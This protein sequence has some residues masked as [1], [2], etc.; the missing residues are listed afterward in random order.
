MN[1]PWRIGGGLL[2]IG[3]V[4]I[5][6]LLVYP[7]HLLPAWIY[8]LM[9]GWRYPQMT[10]VGDGQMTDFGPAAAADRFVVD[11]GSLD[12]S[13]AGRTTHILSDLPDETVVIGLDI[14][15]SDPT[16][17][18]VEKGP[19]GTYLRLEL[20][21]GE[22][23]VVIDERAPLENW[24]WS[25]RAGEAHR[26]FIYRSGTAKESR[27]LDVKADG[28]WGTYFEPRRESRYTLTTDV[29]PDV[30]LSGAFDARLLAKGGGWK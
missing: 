13:R 27:R 24:V 2:L 11:L 8:D 19:L 26:A 16:L 7:P 28:G 1:R 15:S 23:E 30:S 18:V 12:L 25:R 14:R 21:N 9:Y 22:G 5:V 29:Q 10:M 6:G 20:V 17:D 4:T 3:A